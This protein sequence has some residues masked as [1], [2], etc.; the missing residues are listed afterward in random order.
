M[1]VGAERVPPVQS[2]AK[3]IETLLVC[4]APIAETRRSR[5]NL[6]DLLESTPTTIVAAPSDAVS[7]DPGYLPTT[8][9]LSLFK[10]VLGGDDHTPAVLVVSLHSIQF[11]LLT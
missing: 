1:F 9:V 6:P 3:C 2:D 5:Q 10:M 8:N 11:C 7:A 4:H